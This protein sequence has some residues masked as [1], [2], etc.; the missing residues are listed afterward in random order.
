VFT[1]YAVA[2]AAARS[3]SSTRYFT[4][5]S[6]IDWKVAAGIGACLL[7]VGLGGLAA[8]GGVVRRVLLTTLVNERNHARLYP[9]RT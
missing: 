3:M 9:A 5:A 7:A 1:V 4:Q 6:R 8:L 2:Y